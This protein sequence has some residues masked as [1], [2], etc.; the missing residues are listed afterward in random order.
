MSL[1]GLFKGKLSR[2]GG[3]QNIA[4]NISSHNTSE[5]LTSTPHPA[6]PDN[7]VPPPSYSE[8][9]DKRINTFQAPIATHPALPSPSGASQ[10]L[11]A[12]LSIPE[13]PYA[14]LSTFDTVFVI[15]DSGSMA[16]RSWHE[17]KE[18]LRA[19]TPIYT[20]YSDNGVDVY[21]LNAKNPAS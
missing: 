21:V 1:L 16:S 19:I 2:K 9:T 7:Q 18:V 14:F 5:R 8:A 4:S 20:A 11:V 6:L 15:D 3:N 10:T 17:V 13:D 12:S